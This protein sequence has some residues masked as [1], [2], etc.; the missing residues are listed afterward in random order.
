MKN[1]RI[2]TGMKLF[3]A[4]VVPTILFGVES[5]GKLKEKEKNALN[6]IQ[7][8]FLTKLLKVPRTT[9]KSALMYEC[10]QMKIEHQVNKRKLEYYIELNNREKDKLEVKIK[11]H[12][13][14]RDNSYE[15]DIYELKTKYGITSNIE[16][17]DKTEALK[18][19]N[20][21]IQKKNKEEIEEEL[22]NGSKTKEILN[23]EKQNY[24]KSENF[25]NAKIIFQLKFKMLDVKE[26]YKRKYE[27]NLICDVCCDQNE[28]QLHLFKC[29][30]YAD[31]TTKIKGKESVNEILKQNKLAE[32]A[33]TIKEVMKRKEIIKE[34][35]QSLRKEVSAKKGT[36]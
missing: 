32:I 7:T 24:I 21:N 1:N 16:E 30:M 13:K 19:I 6:N 23:Q 10:N 11:D 22:R 17:M 36:N 5:W 34:I 9:P 28:D 26:N 8:Q 25:E 29:V 2:K 33:K 35:K 18:D 12:C 31:I 14:L 20:E 27:P 4:C 3:N 15:K